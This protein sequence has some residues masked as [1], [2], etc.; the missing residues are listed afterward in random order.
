MSV[1]NERRNVKELQKKLGISF[2]VDYTLLI[3][4]T[5]RSYKNEHKEI[6]REDNERM[7]FIAEID[8]TPE[9]VAMVKG[10]FKYG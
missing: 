9:L 4:I 6:D 2:R 7:E 1:S 8:L 3:A 10:A 5:R